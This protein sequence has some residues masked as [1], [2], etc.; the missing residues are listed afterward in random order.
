[1]D[2]YQTQNSVYEIDL[3]NLKYRRSPIRGQHVYSQRLDYDVWHP[4]SDR[5]NPVEFVSIEGKN[6]LRIF[7]EDAVHGIV[8]T[9]I[10]DSITEKN[11]T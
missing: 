4:L 9:E 11:E 5:E 1:M 10:I 6:C 8:T 7:H 2:T 3:E